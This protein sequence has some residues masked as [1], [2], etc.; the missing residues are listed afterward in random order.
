MEIMPDGI[1]PSAGG[2]G[3][4]QA[5]VGAAS[6]PGYGQG[7][8]ARAGAFLADGIVLSLEK[9]ALGQATVFV[10]GYPSSV[11]IAVQAAGFQEDLLHAGLIALRGLGLIGLGFLLFE[12]L[13]GATPGKLILRLRVVQVDGRPCT[14]QSAAVRDVLRLVDGLCLGIPAAASMEPPLE[15]RI[16]DRAARAIVVD[17]RQYGLQSSRSRVWLPLAAGLYPAI[18]FI[19]QLV[20]TRFVEGPHT[21]ANRYA[22]LGAAAARSGDSA[23]AAELTERAILVRV[24]EDDL[25]SSYAALGRFY[26]QVQEADKPVTAYQQ[27]L[28]QD[29]THLRAWSGLGNAYLFLG[30]DDW[31]EESYRHAVELDPV[32]ADGHL[33]L[34][35]LAVDSAAGR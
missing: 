18:S 19:S 4:V 17:A 20:L 31:A 11:G 10:L 16:G 6:G 3:A 21:S 13:Y 8:E 2:E 1:V 24:A 34:A 28:G 12:W 33:G 35:W 29:P 22:H 5:R 23:G 27:A 14:L 30:H 9:P 32:E 25:A 26:M 7:F 15:Q